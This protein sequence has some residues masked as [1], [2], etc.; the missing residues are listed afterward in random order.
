M[1]GIPP[2]TSLDL[3]SFRLV[4]V[5]FDGHGLFI[6]ARFLPSFEEEEGLMIMKLYLSSHLVT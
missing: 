3:D 1:D 6:H 5:T 2:L 4:K